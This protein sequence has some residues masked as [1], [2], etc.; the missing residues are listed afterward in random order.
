MTHEQRAQLDD[1]IAQAENGDTIP[2]H[3]VFDRIAKRFGF[4]N[5]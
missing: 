4:S 2:A 5:A 1:G 3:D